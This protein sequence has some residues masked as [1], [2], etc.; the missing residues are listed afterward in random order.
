MSQPG[1]RDRLLWISLLASP[2]FWLFSF[3]AKFS[4]GP[5]ACASQTKVVLFLFSLIAFL[6]SAAAGFL[7]RRQ[8][9]ELGNQQPG[10][11][12]GP[13]ARSRF[14]ALG[15][16]VF[17]ISF[18]MVIVAQSIPDLILGACQ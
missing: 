11:S 17:S 10:E 16:M 14:M 8:W 18:C 7:A 9:K 3:Q 4:W 2:V 12:S 5:L 15:G 1:T 13:L 6:L